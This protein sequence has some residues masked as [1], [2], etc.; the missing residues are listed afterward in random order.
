M[1]TA[2]PA[3]GGVAPALSVALGILRANAP[4]TVM[5]APEDWPRWAVLLPHVLSA[6]A[7]LPAGDVHPDGRGDATSV[8]ENCS[9]LLDKASA[10]L[11]VEG[12]FTEARPLLDR[13]LAIDEAI[14]GP[15]HPTV[16]AALSNL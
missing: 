5:A 4:G 7:R 8:W 6:T 3:V 12:R 10:Y 14:H 16:A 11:Q 15:D 2:S 1:T 13:A 9:W